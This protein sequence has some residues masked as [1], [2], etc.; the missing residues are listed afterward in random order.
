MSPAPLRLT[1]ALFVL[2]LAGP[3]AAA[4]RYVAPSGSDSGSGSS[5][6]PWK[7]LRY[8]VANSSPGDTIHVADGNYA[9]FHVEGDE[10]GTASQPKVFVADN[11]YGAHISGASTYSGKNAVVNIWGNH[12]VFDGFDI[13]GSSAE[14]GVVC[15]GWSFYPRG[16]VLRNSKVHDASVMGVFSSFCDDMVIEN[17]EITG[18][19]VSHCVYFSNSGDNPVAR[20]NHIHDCA[21]TGIHT[22][23]DYNIDAPAGK[24]GMISGLIY[25]G[26][27]IH[28]YDTNGVHSPAISMDGVEDATLINNVI[29]DTNGGQGMTAFTCDG[30]QGPRNITLINNTIVMSST[31]GHYAVKVKGG[32]GEG[33]GT[34]GQNDRGGHL[35]FNNVIKHLGASSSRG[36]LRIESSDFTSNNNVLEKYNQRGSTVYS[37]LAAW[38]ALGHD[39]ASFLAEVGTLFENPAGDDYHL[40]PGSLAENAGI[41]ALGGRSAP[42]TDFEGDPRLGSPDIGADE[43]AMAVV[44]RRVEAPA[45]DAEE[46]A[47]GA[48]DLDDP[49]LELVVDGAAQTVGVRFVVVNVPQGASVTNAWVQFKAAEASSGAAVLTIEGQKALSPPAFTTAAGNISSRPTTVALQVWSPQ[50]WTAGAAGAGQRT[51]DLSAILEEIVGQPGWVA[52]NSIVLIFSGTGRRVAESFE[53]DAGGAPLLHVEYSG[54]GDDPPGPPDAPENLHRTDVED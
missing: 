8:A 5:G 25:D 54:G 16:V 9:A 18:T 35:F 31:S 14:K 43:I 22:N 19:E 26:N 27:I 51:P 12:I 47:D 46:H 3:A 20:G 28:D 32:S 37:T 34:E 13:D 23:G 11:P 53:G 33:C 36:S 38:Q 24:D 44:D 7:T 49:H 50:A 30:F 17:N 45:D 39:A 52:G 42:D 1:A 6:S 41:A 40:L 4:E 29:Y 48:V 15:Y 2:C 21:D 10:G